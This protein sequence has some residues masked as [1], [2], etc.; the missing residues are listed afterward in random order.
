MDIRSFRQWLLLMAVCYSTALMGQQVTISAQMQNP[1]LRAFFLSDFNFTGTGTSSTPI[2]SITMSNTSLTAQECDLTVTI[3]AENLGD[4]A[5]GRTSAFVIEPMKPIRITNQNL[6]S[7]ALEFHLEEY[8]IARA[9][10]EL[11]R[12][13][14]STGKLPSDTYYFTFALHQRRTDY[15]S[16]AEISFRVDNPNT[17]TLLAPG[18]EAGSG[19]SWPVSTTWPMFRWNSNLAKFRLRIAEKLPE[20]HASASPEEIINDRIR[21]D[22][23]FILDPENLA[24]VSAGEEKITSTAFQYPVAGVWTL[25]RGKTYYWQIIGLAPS[26]GGELEMPSEIWA[27]KIADASSGFAGIHG[28][29]FSQLQLLLGEQLAAF[30]SASGPLAGYSPTGQFMMNGRS[31]TLEQVLALL[32]KMNDGEYVITGVT[33]N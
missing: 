23:T 18:Q 26:S 33:C 30:L 15:I 6:F 9:G 22:R 31:A 5:E 3:R 12:R 4:L 21:F 1:S 25:E 29:L 11:K 19:E 2:F 8:S 17:L 16:Q 14:L 24:S 20:L 7:K 32:A 27:F 10:D 13:I 28:I